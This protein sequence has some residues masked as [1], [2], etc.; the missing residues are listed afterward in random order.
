[1]E[2]VSLYVFATTSGI[3]VGWGIRQTLNQIPFGNAY[4][5]EIVSGLIRVLF[6]FY[7]LRQPF[8][9]L[10]TIQKD[11][12]PWELAT[13]ISWTICALGLPMVLPQI[14]RVVL[15]RLRDSA[16]QW[17]LTVVA[18]ILS[19]IIFTL[20][21]WFADYTVQNI[22]QTYPAQFPGAQRMLTTIGAVYGWIFMLYL[23]AML[24]TIA[25]PVVTMWST[26]NL[27]LRLTA[28]LPVLV[29]LLIVVPGLVSIS[30]AAMS[31]DKDGR[32]A[33]QG[34]VVEDLILWTSFMPNQVGDGVLRNGKGEFVQQNHLACRNLPP[35]FYVAFVHPDEVGPDKVFVAEP[36]S[37][38]FVERDL[39]YNYRVSA[40]ENSINPSGIK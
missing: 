33:R 35:E 14:W 37:G 7:Y 27:V 2:A 31:T 13:G 17:L 18:A 23:L 26:S 24:A 32:H 19:Y 11:P 29:A 1:M 39:A 3:G 15:D 9:F 34:S 8:F 22:M 36:K 4:K 30:Q 25:T 10:A 12:Q 28:P 16:S 6:L 21:Q 38:G 40:C 20:A 5:R